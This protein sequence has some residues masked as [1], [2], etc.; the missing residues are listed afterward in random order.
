MAD[1]KVA[2]FWIK[3]LVLA[4]IVL[5]GALIVLVYVPEN[6]AESGSAGSDS[7]EN[8][9]DNLASFYEEFRL[10]SKDPIQEQYGDFVIALETSEQSQTEQLVAISNVDKPPEENWQGQYKFRS[11]A[12]GN[13]IRTEAMKYAEQEGMQLLWDLN[14]DFIIRHRFLSEN[15]LVA[16]LDEVAGAIDANFVPQVNVYFC[17][18]KR[19]IVIAENAGTY[20][21]ENCKKAGFD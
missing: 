8:I 14:Q 21:T 1:K 19:T 20:V 18:Q 9:S 10:S 13:T 2:A 12:Q 5:A 16:T 15:S 4:F 3:H 6:G 11:F 17:N 7:K